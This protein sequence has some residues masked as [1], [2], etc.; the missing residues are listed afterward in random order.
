MRLT[1]YEIFAQQYDPVW[2][3][4]KEMDTIVEFLALKNPIDHL[5]FMSKPNQEVT[6]KAISALFYPRSMERKSV[7]LKRGM[8]FLDGKERELML[9][10]G[11]FAFSRVELDSLVTLLLDASS[12]GKIKQLGPDE[13]NSRFSLIDADCSG[14]LDRWEI[15]DFFRRMGMSLNETVLDELMKRFDSNRDGVVSLDEFKEVMR[16]LQKQL[17]HHNLKASWSGFV[18]AV[19]KDSDTCKLDVAYQVSDIDYVKNMG[20]CENEELKMIVGEDLAP[21]TL[22]VYLKGVQVP[23]LVIC[24][25]AGHVEAWARAFC[26]CMQMQGLDGTQP[27]GCIEEP[28]EKWHDSRIDWGFDG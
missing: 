1:G 13:L 2:W 28:P 20:S 19:T 6:K 12:S 23:L 7:L 25:K 9:F 10:T 24:T 15:T 8:V 5:E 3:E 17:D 14:S 11:G 18:K 26:K 22:A 16:K 4:K 27:D 21:F